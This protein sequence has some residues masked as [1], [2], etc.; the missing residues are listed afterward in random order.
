MDE[1]EIAT[2]RKH[3]KEMVEAYEKDGRFLKPPEWTNEIDR[4]NEILTVDQDGEIRKIICKKHNCEKVHKRGE[5]HPN[6]SPY[7]EYWVWR[8]PKCEDEHWKRY[9]KDY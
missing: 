9:W 6:M 7:R 3:L 8:C 5:L 1:E 4:E 2:Y